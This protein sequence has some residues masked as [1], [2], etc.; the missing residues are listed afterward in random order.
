MKKLLSL[1]LL[2]CT[3][4]TFA[5]TELGD[6]TDEMFKGESKKD[7][8]KTFETEEGPSLSYYAAAGLSMSNNQLGD[9]KGTSYP[10]VELGVMVENVAVGLV[11][12]FSS[13]EDYSL[14]GEIKTA[15]YFPLGAVDGYAV[16]GYGTY[17][18]SPATFIE[19]GGGISYAPDNVGFFLQ[20]TKWDGIWYLTPGLCINF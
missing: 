18:N 13:L 10:S 9:F 4:V 3:T 12:G 15:I 2:L 5:Q 20:T 11:G 7:T 16:M 8:V 17:F 19:Y 6:I 1:A 14:W